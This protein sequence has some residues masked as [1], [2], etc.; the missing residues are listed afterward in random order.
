MIELLIFK[1]RFSGHAAY[2][3]IKKSSAYYY[4]LQLAFFLLLMSIG[5]AL[6]YLQMQHSLDKDIHSRLKLA[7]VSLD[8]IPGHT[9]MAANRAKSY[10]RESCREEVVSSFRAIGAT[11]PDVITVSMGRLIEI[12]CSSFIGKNTFSVNQPDYPDGSLL[13]MG[14][15]QIM[16]S[17]SLVVYTFKARGGNSVLIGVNRFYLYNVLDSF[18]GDPFLNLKIGELYL[19]RYGHISASADIRLPAALI[20]GKSRYLVLTDRT[21]LSGFSTF[22]H[23]EWNLFIA[24]LVVSLLLTWLLKSYLVFRCTLVYML[25]KAMKNKQLK[26][27]IQ[28]IVNGVTG[29]IVGGE[30]L[31]RWEHPELGFIP[32]DKFISVAEQ[33]GLVKEVTAICFNEVTRQL[34]EQ[35]YIL[36]NGLFICFNVSAINFKGDD[37]V[38]L[39]TQFLSLLNVRIV[40]EITEREPIEHTLQTDAVIGML[41]QLGIHFSLD[42][43]GTGHAN[44]SYLQQFQPKYIKIDKVF[45]SNIETNAASALIVK[46]MINLARKFDCQIIAEGV[47]DRIQLQLLRGLGIDIFQGYYFSR[48][49]PVEDYIQALRIAS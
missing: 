14:S 37:I 40:L 11:I 26:P 17:K 2:R 28:P 41:Q 10:M 33:T 6:C 29:Q 16:P 48:P 35:E 15:N 19:N 47:E 36:P 7:I 4:P 38:T 46:N 31:V 1:R 13:L 22:V 49:L 18:D 8:M 43:F 12:Y 27:F 20:S 21:G 3:N 34:H 5:T 25:R 39:C 24:I 30:V 42:D 44:Y 32:P 23:Y 45:T 9:E